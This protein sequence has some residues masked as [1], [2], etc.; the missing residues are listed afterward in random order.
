MLSSVRQSR[1]AALGCD[2]D[3]AGL[4]LFRDLTLQFDRE[5]AV[6]ELRPRDLDMVGELEPALEVASGDAAIEVL[7]LAFVVRRVVC[8]RRATCS[9]R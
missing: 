1:L 2:L 9:S 8:R 6:G 4:L 3:G 7:L 5:Q